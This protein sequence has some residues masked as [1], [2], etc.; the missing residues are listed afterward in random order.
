MPNHSSMTEAE[1]DRIA[2][3]IR[4]SWE[5]DDAPFKPSGMASP[6]LDALLAGS[7]PGTGATN[8]HVSHT[9]GAGSIAP[10]AITMIE[11]AEPDDLK[12]TIDP[13][14]PAAL[15]EAPLV[16]APIRTES[17]PVAVPA[18]MPVPTAQI[19]AEAKAVSERP[20]PSS[21]RPS[22]PPLP[23]QRASQRPSQSVSAQADP[24]ALPAGKTT[25]KTPRAKSTS[26]AEFP[27]IGKSNKGLYIA[28]SGGAVVALIVIIA[29]AASP[30][31]PDTTVKL[32]PP[33]KIGAAA[34]TRE[35]PPPPATED[36]PATNVQT[37][38]AA[39]PTATAPAPTQA[40]DVPAPTTT[41]VAQAQTAT[42]PPVP[43]HAS[44][45]PHNNSTTHT[46]PPPVTHSNPPPAGGAGTSGKG[47]GG[48][49]R[50]VPF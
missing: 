32:E 18:P 5:L 11:A 36:L 38:Q 7:L 45:P 16:A 21:Q 43:T 40:A 9:N 17:P 12:T 10:Q 46:S 27:A 28:L 22:A 13:V 14:P 24:F 25:G 44:N 47:K 3:G 49:V 1:L 39:Q 37:A 50:D 4:P 26:S 19:V 48:I 34:Q 30:S 42:P 15:V 2:A 23:S 31:K 8:G 20:P 35:I 29:F 6:Q 33:A 41:Q